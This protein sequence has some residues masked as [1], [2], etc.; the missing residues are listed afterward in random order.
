[1]PPETEECRTEEENVVVSRTSKGNATKRPVV[2]LRHLGTVIGLAGLVVTMSACSIEVGEP[3]ELASASTTITQPATSV[4]QSDTLAPSTTQATTTEAPTTQP[5]TTQ[6]PTTVSTTQAPTT[7]APTTSQATVT[8]CVG[9]EKPVA[10][11][12]YRVVNVASDDVLNIRDGAGVSN[13]VIGSY[14]YDAQVVSP[15]GGCWM[16]N[17]S[18]WWEVDAGALGTGWVHS[19]FL[20]Q[21]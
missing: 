7:A 1:M 21:N 19:G 14:A 15:L 4:L 17:S 8:T 20:A 11:A 10:G 18:P 9:G 3:E 6:P 16:V 13:P 2:S 5:P 12:T